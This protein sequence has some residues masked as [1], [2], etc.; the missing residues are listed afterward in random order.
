MLTEDRHPC[1]ERR[2]GEVVVALVS[3]RLC[4]SAGGANRGRLEVAREADR[5]LVVAELIPAVDVVQPT[6]SYECEATHDDEQTN[7]R[8][9]D[10]QSP[11]C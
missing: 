8:G 2:R 3:N 4:D 1:G 9:E 5:L 7:E 6:E 11:V 10:G